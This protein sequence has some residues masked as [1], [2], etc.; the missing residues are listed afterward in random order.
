LLRV[1]YTILPG[2]QEKREIM[3]PRYFNFVTVVLST[4]VVSSTVCYCIE[5]TVNVQTL[6]SNCKGGNPPG[7]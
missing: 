7:V 5:C 1:Y 3:A 2:R 4:L 6:I